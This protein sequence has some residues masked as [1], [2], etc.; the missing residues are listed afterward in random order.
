MALE[1]RCSYI[2]QTDGYL[3][4]GSVGATTAFVLVEAPLPW[5]ADVG[6]HPLLAPL[7]PV[8]GGARARLQA[9]VPQ[10]DH[11]PDETRVVVYRR[12]AGGF[13]RYDRIERS[14]PTGDLVAAV[15]ELLEAPAGPGGVG[16]GDAITDVLVC[17]HGSRDVCC[18]AGGMRVHKDLVARDLPGVRVW[19]TSH[20]GGHRFAPTAVTLPDGRAWAWVDADFLERLVARTVPVTEAVVRDR[21]CAGLDDP[22]AQTAESAVLG[23][24]G[25]GWL[26]RAR[27]AEVEPGGGDHRR[28]TVTGVDPHDGGDLVS[29]RAEVVLRRVV[30]VPDCGRPLDEA[31]KSAPE[32]EVVSLDRA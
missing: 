15:A 27:H 32:L 14:V 5:P 18:G 23:A 19:R 12:S 3:P 26:D 17:T 28:V 11:G 6:A 9:V 25:W 24:E 4:A 10:G 1:L 16:A 31:R 20:T 21:G 7:A 8:V 22:F 30:P 29:Y 13:V 2:A